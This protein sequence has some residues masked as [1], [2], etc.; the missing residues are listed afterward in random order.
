MC[1]CNTKVRFEIDGEGIYLIEPIEEAKCPAFDDCL[2]CLEFKEK[3]ED[4]IY[5]AN[6]YSTVY[7]VQYSEGIE[8]DGDCYINDIIKLG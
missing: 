3:L 4:G 8:Y 5:E 1:Q 6:F 2:Y 7:P